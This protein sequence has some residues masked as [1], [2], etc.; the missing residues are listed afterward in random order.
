[1]EVSGASC[2]FGEL[3]R[4]RF[5]PKIRESCLQQMGIS[6]ENIGP[7]DIQGAM[8][9]ILGSMELTLTQEGWLGEC[10]TR[11]CKDRGLK[12]S[13]QSLRIARLAEHSWVEA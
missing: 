4:E 13:P 9:G 12:A 11:L 3:D 2:G 5:V 1:M 10:L 7:E 6:A 8:K